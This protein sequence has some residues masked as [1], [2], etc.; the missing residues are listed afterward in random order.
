MVINLAESYF[1]IEESTQTPGQSQVRRAGLHATKWK[2]LI[3]LS[4][5]FGLFNGEL[6]LRKAPSHPFLTT[7]TRLP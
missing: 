6:C 1:V 3:G 7:L 4:G 5:V 2:Y